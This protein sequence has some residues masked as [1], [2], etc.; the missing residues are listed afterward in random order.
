MGIGI[1]DGEPLNLMNFSQISDSNHHIIKATK[2]TKVISTRMMAAG[3]YEGKSVI[4]FSGANFFSRQ[5]HPTYGV[6]GSGTQWIALYT[7]YEIGGV[8]LKNPLFLYRRG[9]IENHIFSG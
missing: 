2:A 9:F 3:T 1:K 7:T 6:P 5:D 8:H 4:E